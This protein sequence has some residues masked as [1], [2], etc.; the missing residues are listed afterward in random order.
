MVQ[1]GSPFY[2]PGVIDPTNWDPW[3]ARNQVFSVDPF[4]PA[5]RRAG[6]LEAMRAAYEDGLVFLGDIDIPIIDWRHYLEAELNMHNAHQSFASRQRIS[7][8]RGNSDNQV[9]WFTD[10]LGGAQFD[11]TPE[12]LDVM[13][14]WMMNILE[15][16]GLGVAGNKPDLAVDRCFD[17]FG[18][19]IASG[20]DVWDGILDDHTPGDCTVLFPVFETSR[21]VAGGPFKGSIFKCELKPVGRAI[22]D[23]D[24]G[25]WAPT[26][27]E[28][29]MLH[30]IFPSGVC[31]FSEPDAG[32]PPGW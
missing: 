18:D 7:D 25:A 14:D 1:E 29:A 13:D 11:Q 12:A 10:A 21:I 3:S 9:V 19:E 16:P 23:G 26:P 27:T 30:Q 24:Y 22:A 17:T 28:Q 8:Y 5:P 31:D 6:D 4:V 15:N 20:D 2:P 32:W